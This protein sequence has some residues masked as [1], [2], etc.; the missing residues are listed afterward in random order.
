MDASLFGR[1]AGEGLGVHI[2]TGPVYVRGA[3]EGDVI[4]LR[5]IDVAPR[6]CANPKYPGKA[7][8]SNAAAWWGFHYKDLLTEPK[9]REVVT[10][11]EVDATG[12]R[13]WAKAVYNFR[14]TPQTDP[15]GRG[16]QDDRLP[17]R[18]GRPSTMKENHGILKNVRIP[19]RPHFG[20]IGLAP[21]EADIVDS[22]PPSYT[23]GNID[24]WRIGKGAT[25]YYP[26]AVEGAPVIGWRLARFAGRLRIVRYGDRMLADM[27][28]SRSSCTRRRSWRAPRSGALDFPMLET[29]DEWLVHGFSFANYLTEFGAKAQ[30]DIYS[31]SSVDLALRDAFRK[32]RKFLM[33]TKKLTEDEAIS[34]IIHRGGLRD[35]PSRRRQLGRSRR[36]QKGYLRGWRGLIRAIKGTPALFVEPAVPQ[37][38]VARSNR[39]GGSP[40]GSARGRRR[41]QAAPGFRSR[42]ARCWAERGEAPE[43]LRKIHGR[44]SGHTGSGGQDAMG[45]GVVASQ[46]NGNPCQPHRLLV[47]SANELGQEAGAV[48][49]CGQR[50]ARAQAHRAA[51]GLASFFPATAK[52]QC[53]GIIGLRLRKVRVEVAVPTRIRP[54]RRRTAG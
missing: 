51:S 49:K 31:K 41:V 11:Y 45:C 42:Q 4:E 12:E 28:P 44:S 25:M 43:E 17:W 29:Q 20:V 19:V 36:D 53:R 30:S 7:F 14:W 52:S 10:I 1:G 38:V 13:N 48:I 15:F 37:T 26:V 39:R 34:L 27:A 33:T 46:A 9:P 5:I 16:A 50:I 23:G 6:P 21:K 32:M 2:C 18:A 54:M 40:R 24:N 3:Q 8:G 47:I 22:I 35:H